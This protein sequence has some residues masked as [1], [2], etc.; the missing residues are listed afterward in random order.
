VKEKFLSDLRKAREAFT[1]EELTKVGFVF[2]DG[3]LN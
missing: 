3:Q 2:S 1:G